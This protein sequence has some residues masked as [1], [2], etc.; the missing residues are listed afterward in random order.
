M[1]SASLYI[2]VSLSYLCYSPARRSELGKTVPEVLKYV[3][4]LND[5]HND[6]L[7]FSNI[8]KH[9][10]LFQQWLIYKEC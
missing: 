5:Y 1:A 6:F 3:L 4:K 8:T 9:I 10:F 2:H 7:F